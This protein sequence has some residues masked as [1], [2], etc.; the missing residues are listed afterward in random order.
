MRG[1]LA[2]TLASALCGMAPNV[3]ALQISRILQGIGAA[4][5]LPNSL[6]VLNQTFA[7]PLHRSNAISA[8]A[9]AGAIGVALGPVLGGLLV[10]TL[11]WRSIFLVNV[12]VGLLALWLTQ[13]HIPKAPRNASRSLDPLGQLLAVATLATATYCLI[14][15]SHAPPTTVLPWTSGVASVVF[16]IG[17]VAVEARH[18]SPML[19]L[20]LQH[21]TSTRALACLVSMGVTNTA[22]LVTAPH[23]LPWSGML[24][25]RIAPFRPP[26][27]MPMSPASSE[28]RSGPCPN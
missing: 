17:F 18:V 8:W 13:R 5:L 3:V 14:G 11:G 1:L 19:P 9:S 26:T 24:T 23:T 15:M 4:L 22:S 28:S 7:D 25:S 16:S 27:A 2:F 6:A 12:P 20:P 21:Q 10:Q